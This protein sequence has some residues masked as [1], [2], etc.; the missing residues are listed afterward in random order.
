MDWNAEG[1]QQDFRLSFHFGNNFTHWFLHQVALRSSDT[2]A[3]A[4]KVPLFSR[5]ATV[6]EHGHVIAAPKGQPFEC[7]YLELPLILT[8]PGSGGTTSGARYH[9]RLAFC[10]ARLLVGVRVALSACV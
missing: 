10:L 5:A 3:V 7:H 2:T 4:L 9:P 8:S 6:Q 1:E